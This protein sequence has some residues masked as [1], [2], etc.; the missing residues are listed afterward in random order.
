MNILFA[1]TPEFAAGF[2]ETLIES[3][4][5]VVAVITQPDR[6]GKRGKKLLPSP[7]KELAERARL[8]VI[9]PTKLALTDIQHLECDLMLYLT[10]MAGSSADSA[11]HSRR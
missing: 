5:N 6:P 1:G 3:K 11:R 9:Q 10:Q 8:T 2:L 7:V 4:H